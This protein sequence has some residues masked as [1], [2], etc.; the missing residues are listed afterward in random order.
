MSE[1][2][3][4]IMLLDE[5]G[6][7]YKMGNEP[8]QAINQFVSEQKLKETNGKFSFYTFNSVVTN[9]VH[10]IPI[11]DVPEFTEY[12][13]NSMTS[14]YDVI[15]D[16]IALKSTEIQS[17]DDKPSNV[18]CVIL[19]DGHDTSSKKYGKDEISSMIKNYETNHKWTFIYL[20]ANQDAFANDFGIKCCAQF[21]PSPNGILEIVRS[22]S[23][24]I[25]EAVS[26]PHQ[27]A[28]DV[29]YRCISVQP[30]VSV[31]IQE[32]YL[33]ISPVSSPPL[34]PL[35]L[36]PPLKRFKKI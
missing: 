23:I 5:S 19:T 26:A 3:D 18:I 14:L 17:E 22:T 9:V 1:R 21:D 11:N 29:L 16:A 20:A 13:P 8:I 36:P 6:S 25:T 34:S 7:M 33:T 32:S 28:S 12:N 10:N 2:T 15:G 35:L 27:N 4:I 31:P 24:A 30:S